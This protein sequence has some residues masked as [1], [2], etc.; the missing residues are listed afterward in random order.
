VDQT[1]YRTRT[2]F[3]QA[4]VDV[5]LYFMR[6]L[7][8]DE[9]I[10][11]AQGRA[12]RRDVN[13]VLVLDRSSSMNN[14]NSCEPMKS[15]AKT[16]VG[17]FA[18]SRDTLGLITYGATHY[19]AFE[20]GQDFKSANPSLADQIDA[21]TCTGNTST[22]MALS[23]AHEM[24]E[25]VDEPGVLNL[26][27]LFTYGLSNGA[28]ARYPVKELSD[29]GHG[30]GKDGYRNTSELYNMP[31]SPCE[32]A[33]GH[34]YD[35]NASTGDEYT[36]PP[37]NPDWAPGDKLGVLSQWSGF[38]EYGNTAGLTKL[39]AAYLGAPDNAPIGDRV[40]CRFGAN[41]KYARRDVAF[42]PDTDYYG[43]ST[44]GYK[45]VEEFPA[46]HAYEGRIR[47]DKPPS[48]GSASFNP[49]DNAAQQV[50]DDDYLDP[51]IYTIGLGDPNSSEPP[52]EELMRRIANDPLSAIH[53]P[54]EPE[55]LYVFAPDNSELAEAFYR[56]AS[57]ILRLS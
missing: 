28:T 32:D 12:S 20:P 15:A 9:S 18:N 42:I 23:E 27:V 33:S 44:R 39:E 13:L 4:S 5:G 14:S 30:Y 21:T 55:G 25:E 34:T 49:A 31:P 48:I 53:D 51:V 10:V 3:V 6:V 36:A 47:P 26:V 24:L 2:V 8:R 56:G 40:G 22:A 57:D 11:R 7:G 35:R 17:H 45:S 19:V 43:N 46:G 16:F 38:A 1:G 37:W 52:D 50:R 41:R 29:L 54:T